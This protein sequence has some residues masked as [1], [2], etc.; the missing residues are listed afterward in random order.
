VGAEGP[1]PSRIRLALR[2]GLALAI[3]VLG[4]SAPDRSAGRAPSSPARDEP[5]T[6][7]EGRQPFLRVLGTA[8]D[9]GIPHAACGCDRCEAARR[10]PYR[11]RRIASL[12]LAIPAANKVY[13]IDAGP[14]LREQLEALR[15]VRPVPEGGT[16]RAPLAGIF[17]THAHMGHYAGLVFLGFESL[18]VRRLPVYGSA[19]MVAFLEENGPWSQMV[20]LEEI[21]PLVVEPGRPIPLEDGLSLTALVV[22]H[23][24][25]FTDTLAYWIRGPRAS[26]FYAPD[27]DGWEGWSVPLE[28]VVSRADV[29][30]LD[31]TFY[32]AD[33]LPDRDLAPIA[34]PFIRATMDRLGRLGAGKVFFTHLNHSNPALDPQAPARREIVSR[35]YRLLEDGE[36]F[37]L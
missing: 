2:V 12:A 19:R 22:P 18:H 15:D 10:D 7:D 29:A 8:Q 28:E 31:G 33:E 11:R 25:E 16:D 17:L 34:H 14:D 13:L 6:R 1:R 5:R 9:G 23:R 21:E 32:S 26:V 36:E 20:R 27:T 35:G 37:P 3:S 30:L 4:C 24:A